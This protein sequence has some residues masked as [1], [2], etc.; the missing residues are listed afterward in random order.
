MRESVAKEVLIG[1]RGKPNITEL[2][3]T[4]I[5]VK[6]GAEVQE[7]RSRGHESNRHD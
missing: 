2:K 3:E 7:P 4:V 1:R 5:N 6:I